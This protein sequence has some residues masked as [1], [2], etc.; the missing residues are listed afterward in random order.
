MNFARFRRSG[1]NAPIRTL[2]MLGASIIIIFLLG[3]TLIFLFMMAG[4]HTVAFSV[5]AHSDFITMAIDAPSDKPS[6]FRLPSATL[7][8][9]IYD[10]ALDDFK[11]I[12]NPLNGVVSLVIEGEGVIIIQT[13][14]TG[15]LLIEATSLPHDTSSQIRIYDE[16][17]QIRDGIRTASLE[18]ECYHKCGKEANISLLLEA[19]KIVIGQTQLP[20]NEPVGTGKQPYAISGLTAGSI[21]AY[22]QA[23][24]YKTRF[25]LDRITLDSGDVLSLAGVEPIIGRVDFNANSSNNG[26]LSIIAHTQGQ[27]LSIDRFGGGHEFSVDRYSALAQEPFLQTLWVTLVSLIILG[28]FAIGLSELLANFIP[29]KKNPLLNKRDGDDD[30]CNIIS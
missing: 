27:S 17:G 16:S 26:R 22:A 15:H 21:H 28:G 4:K 7:I 29:N 23:L 2:H 25:E 19:K 5:K 8:E 3:C 12:L 30:I 11:P 20:W 10:E 14:S 1:L 18:F 24:L 13:H 9:Q 6:V